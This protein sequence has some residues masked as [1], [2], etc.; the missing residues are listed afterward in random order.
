MQL[1]A[2]S[3]PGVASDSEDNMPVEEPYPQYQ[4]KGKE[5]MNLEW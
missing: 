4:N 1:R 2:N 3:V 5:T